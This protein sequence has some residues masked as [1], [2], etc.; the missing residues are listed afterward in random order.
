MPLDVNIRESVVS[1]RDWFAGV[2]LQG[3]IAVDD[4]R[5]VEVFKGAGVDTE[6][7]Y[8]TMAYG[9]ADAMLTAREVRCD[10]HLAKES[11]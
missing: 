9:F 11:K 8:A 7:G 2:A 3:I 1:L 10:E 5:V 6:K 4:Y